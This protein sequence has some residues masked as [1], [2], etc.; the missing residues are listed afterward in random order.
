MYEFCLLGSSWEA[1]WGPLGAS[2][3]PLGASRSHRGRPLGIFLGRV[4]GSL[5]RLEAIVVV[6][7]RDFGDSRPSWSVLGPLGT[8]VF[9]FGGYLGPSGGVPGSLG[10]PQS[11]FVGCLGARLRTSEA[12]LGRYFGRLR[13]CWGV[14][15]LKMQKR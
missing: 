2:W 12:V 9:C 1:S 14:C 3:S 7:E 13:P 4:G 6:L 8:L 11:A 15:K 5:G 10:S